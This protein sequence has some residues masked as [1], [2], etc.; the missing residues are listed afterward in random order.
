[1]FASLKEIENLTGGLG[2][3]VAGSSFWVQPIK[4]TA[5]MEAANV[6]VI[7]RFIVTPLI[8]KFCF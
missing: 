6:P 7:Q 8:F 1:L 2:A 3:F 4:L 5:A